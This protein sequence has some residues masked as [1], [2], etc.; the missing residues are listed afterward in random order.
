[1][2]KVSMTPHY[3]L[4]RGI[5][6][7]L[8]DPAR[9]LSSG[10]ALSL[11]VPRRVQVGTSRPSSSRSVWMAS[12]RQ[13]G[14]ISKI[15]LNDQRPAPM[16]SASADGGLVLAAVGEHF[17]PGDDELRRELGVERLGV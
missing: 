9:G 3:I 10:S 13:E 1:M 15:S 4:W 5:H 8:P 11:F 17:R 6:L 16:R 2:T 7:S 12:K 14:K